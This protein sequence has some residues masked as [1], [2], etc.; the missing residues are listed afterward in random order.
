[1]TLVTIQ[2]GLRIYCADREKA[3]IVPR[4]NPAIKIM[5]V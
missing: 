3:Y 4:V 1:M 2:P 5:A